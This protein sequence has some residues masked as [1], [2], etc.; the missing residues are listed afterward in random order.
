MSQATCRSERVHAVFEA[1]GE[2]SI[3]NA[4]ATLMDVLAE[5]LLIYETK[6]KRTREQTLATVRHMSKGLQEQLRDA[7]YE[8]KEDE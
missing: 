5:L 7:V 2:T 6:D 3:S 1:L 8:V 4:V